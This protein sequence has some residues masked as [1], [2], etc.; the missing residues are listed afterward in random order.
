MIPITIVDDF[1]DQPRE[2]RDFALNCEYEDSDG[3]WPGSR[4]APLDRL[5]PTM[6]D[7]FMFKF[8]SLF[9]DTTALKAHWEVLGGFQRI[10]SGSGQGWVHRDNYLITAIV[11]LNPDPDPESGTTLYVPRP[12]VIWDMKHLDKK[13]SHHLGLLSTKDAEPF[14]QDHNSQFTESVV[15]K[16]RYNRLLAFPGNMHHGANVLDSNG[17]D[18][19]TLVMFIKSV[20][21]NGVQMPLVRKDFT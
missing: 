1:L 12:G 15:V 19:L 6:S 18:R 8:L 13:R 16:N 14:R 2:W 5:N 9:Y 20:L 11:Y 4:S 3:R 7:R 10:P 17:D 21:V